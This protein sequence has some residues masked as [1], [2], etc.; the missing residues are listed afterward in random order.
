VKRRKVA[1]LGATGLVGQRLVSML[2]DHP[3]F[4]ISE[5][6]GDDSAG[7]LYGEIVDWRLPGSIPNGLAS[8]EVAKLRPSEIDAD[9]VLSALPATVALTVEPQL[10]EQGLAV[11]SDA[12]A[13][14]M[15]ESVPLIVPEVNPDH[16]QLIDEQKYSNG[17]NGFIVTNPNCSTSILS[18]AL[19]PLDDAFG[20]E[21]VSVVTMQALS[22][23]GFPGVSAV[24]IQDN[25]IPYIEHE[26]EKIERESPKILGR[27]KKGGISKK[28]MTIS[29]SCHRVPVTHGHLESVQ[30]KTSDPINS[31]EARELLSKFVGAPQK[32][33]LPSAPKKPILVRDEPDRPQPVLDRDAGTIPGMSIVVG[34]L[35]QGSDR[36][37]LKFDAL[38]HN[39]I[40]G[41]AG[42]TVLT[43]ELLAA[44]GR[45][46]IR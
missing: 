22:G 6:V 27:A 39:L 8:V 44:E 46:E 14:R 7:K 9:L 32:L 38:G 13:H 41:A 3:F 40:R 35:R 4:E 10:A 15:T 36:F 24:A 19:K 43:A 25:I 37:S 20:L 5:M 31:A 45:L 12:S 16:L 1:I 33:H 26:E 42:Q 17:P 30:V 18:L 23:A 11:V 2:G 21:A 29:A 28:Q 34:R